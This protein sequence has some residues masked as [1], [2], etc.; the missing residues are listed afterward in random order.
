MISLSTVGFVIPV[1]LAV[2]LRERLS[3]PDADGSGLSRK[4]NK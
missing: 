1:R 4:E 2:L 3:S